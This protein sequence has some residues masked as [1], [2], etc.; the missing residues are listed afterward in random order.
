M[1]RDAVA[2]RVQGGGF[3]NARHLLARTDPALRSRHFPILT[4]QTQQSPRQHHLAILP[5]LDETQASQPHNATEQLSLEKVSHV[6]IRQSV[7]QVFVEHAIHLC[8]QL[9]KTLMRLS[10][11]CRPQ[12]DHH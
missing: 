7:K 3:G 12:G 5:A 8:R 4:E 9:H 6:R 10:P 1:D 2:Q 11:I